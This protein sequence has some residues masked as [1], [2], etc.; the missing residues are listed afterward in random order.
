MS[1]TRRLLLASLLGAAL[2]PGAAGAQAAPFTLVMLGD[3]LTA[4]FGL[5]RSQAIPA[6]LEAGLKARGIA[7]RVINAG[8][9][10]E[11]SADVLAR[12]DFSVQAGAGA[13]L[14]AVG[15]N[16]LLQ[17]LPPSQLKANLTAIVTRLQARRVK[18]AIAGLQAPQ[19]LGPAYAREFNAVYSDVARAKRAALYPFLLE[20]VALQARLNQNDGIHPNAAGAQII[21]DRLTPFVIR[22]FGLAAA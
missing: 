6:R 22:T 17:G 20:G 2:L 13:A 18:V 1:A 19:N 10:G 3:S 14:V 12:L 16:D 21:A 9:S 5:T 7:A 11:T 15:G 8:A 4:G